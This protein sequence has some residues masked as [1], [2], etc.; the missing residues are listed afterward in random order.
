MGKISSLFRLF[1]VSEEEKN[2]EIRYNKL[3][4]AKQDLE[5][6]WRAFNEVTENSYIDIAIMKLNLAKKQ[7]EV[8]IE[9]NKRETPLLK[10]AN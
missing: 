1:I 6:A 7:L 3:Q 5:N 10:K 9:E 4:E 2:A 8:L